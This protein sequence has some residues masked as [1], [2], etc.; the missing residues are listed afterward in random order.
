MTDTV[1]ING[2]DYTYEEL[3]SFSGVSG[4]E[5]YAAQ[6]RSGEHRIQA[7]AQ[8]QGRQVQGSNSSGGSHRNWKHRQTIGGVQIK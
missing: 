2:T 5:L 1:R 7:F 3:Q 8:S 4:E 6:K